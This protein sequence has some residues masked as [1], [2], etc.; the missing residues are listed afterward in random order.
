MD[1]IKAEY[2]QWCFIVVGEMISHPALLSTGS[3]II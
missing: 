2:K 1:D 3:Y